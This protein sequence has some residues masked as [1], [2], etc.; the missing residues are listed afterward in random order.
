M[1]EQLINAD[2]VRKEMDVM[3]EMITHPEFVASMKA[4]KETPLKKRREFGEQNLT[5]KALKAKGIKLPDGMRVTTRYFEPNK[6]KIIE[7]T[8]DGKIS[9]TKKPQFVIG[10]LIG[11][12]GTLAWGG[13]ACGGGLTFCGGAGGGT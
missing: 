6:P 3:I 7:I 4:M 1:G 11:D 9:I 8:P 5:L 2:K 10:N 12:A 13:C